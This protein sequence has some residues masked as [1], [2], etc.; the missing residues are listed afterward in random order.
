M[1]KR[2][3]EKKRRR[4]GTKIPHCVARATLLGTIEGRLCLER[5][6]EITAH[7]TAVPATTT[8]NGES[9]P[10]E[11]DT[12]VEHHRLRR[13]P[14]L[15]RYALAC[16]LASMPLIDASQFP[17]LADLQNNSDIVIA[18]GTSRGEYRHHN[19]NHNG[20][21]GGGGSS[22]RCGGGGSSSDRSGGDRSSS[23]GALPYV[24]HGGHGGRSGRSGCSRSLAGSGCDNGSVRTAAVPA[25]FNVHLSPEISVKRPSSPPPPLPSTPVAATAKTT[26][27]GSSRYYRGEASVRELV[28]WFRSAAA[29]GQPNANTLYCPSCRR[30]TTKCAIDAGVRLDKAPMGAES[31]TEPTHVYE[32]LW[33]T[34]F[35]YTPCEAWDVRGSGS[36]SG[37]GGGGGDVGI[38]W[39][40]AFALYYPLPSAYVSNDSE[41]VGPLANPTDA[42]P[43]DLFVH[44]A[45]LLAITRD[46][47]VELEDE[48]SNRYFCAAPP[49]YALGKS[50][51]NFAGEE[52]YRNS[53]CAGGAGGAVKDIGSGSGSGSGGSGSGTYTPTALE[54][55]SQHA[56]ICTIRA[57]A[58]A[59]EAART[60]I[61]TNSN[62][63][64]KSYNGG[65]MANHTADAC[66]P[67][68][69]SASTAVSGGGGG[70]VDSGWVGTSRFMVVPKGHWLEGHPVLAWGW[71]ASPSIEKEK[72]PTTRRKKT[73]EESGKE[74]TMK[75]KETQKQTG[76]S[77]AGLSLSS[78]L[79]RVAYLFS[80]AM[81]CEEF[82]SSD[83][84]DVPAMDTVVV[85]ATNLPPLSSL[86]SS[87][88]PP[89]PPPP[90]PSPP[91]YFPAT[92]A[93]DDAAAP[94][95]DP[96]NSKYRS[97]TLKRLLESRRVRRSHVAA[98]EAA[99]QWA[100][101]T[102]SLHPAVS[103]A[104]SIDVQDFCQFCH[105]G[106]ATHVVVD[107]RANEGGED[108]FARQ[109][110]ATFAA[111]FSSL[112][113]NTSMATTPPPTTK[114]TNL[115]AAAAAA[116]RIPA[117][118]KRGARHYAGGMSTGAAR[119]VSHDAVAARGG[120]RLFYIDTLPNGL[121][122]S[123]PTETAPAATA[124][125]VAMDTTAK[126]TD[127]NADRAVASGDED[128]R[129]QHPILPLP[130]LALTAGDTGSAAEI[131]SLC[132]RALPQGTVA[133]T[134]SAGVL[135]DMME[136]RLGTG[137]RFSLSHETH[138]TPEGHAC[139][140]FG[141]PLDLHMPSA[142]AT[143]K[144]ASRS[145]DLGQHGQPGPTV[146]CPGQGTL[147]LGST[148][149]KRK[150]WPEGGSSGA[151]EEEEEETFSCSSGH[152]QEAC[153]PASVL[154]DLW[155]WA[156]QS[157]TY[158][159][160]KPRKS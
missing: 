21:G 125:A 23:D 40:S 68:S 149:E 134:P 128:E 130:V 36:D 26:P 106:G 91:S 142:D 94:R 99:R 20:C 41:A 80:A 105:D 12:G 55:W 22:S 4:E 34:L 100:C 25:R 16:A 90:P 132:V 64:R 13:R 18:A 19:N 78:P 65:V 158:G 32:T 92:T 6:L 56:A 50:D 153:V 107:V 62:D 86:A 93:N 10:S 138:Y 126:I 83:E 66:D 2:K 48:S 69:S 47:H 123:S 116:Q 67:T 104:L 63:K 145:N 109:L 51:D 102:T 136:P 11:T 30:D 70:G 112:K 115:A 15:W 152:T 124:T 29:V 95:T 139:E 52:E 119:F 140:G 33:R 114:T 8:N 155:G 135:S 137:W 60:M 73:K 88:H 24:C 74:E 108:A 82:D 79:P 81:D 113:L 49:T 28:T 76:G 129:R 72:V 111:T 9:T 27:P 151:E 156:A 98:A 143:G 117:Y 58:W 110:A 77:A 75:K 87:S 131:F 133:G 144:T 101:Q 147:G 14:P 150:E 1:I 39:P 103:R 38:N 146:R 84:E 37:G 31:C 71:L 61:A 159:V 59:A 17:R 96:S 89:P 5:Q 127:K 57:R 44:L 45:E 141:V 54:R 53:S 154:P 160:P 157:S 85:N 46:A 7:S 35:R 3:E 122:S 42:P 121:A 120:A 97:S 148:K 118:I 43:A